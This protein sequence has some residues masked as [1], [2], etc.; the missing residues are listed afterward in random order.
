ML[1]GKQTL[2][3]ATHFKGLLL[4]QDFK[5][6]AQGPKVALRMVICGPRGDGNFS[7]INMFFVH[8]GLHEGT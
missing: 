4:G 3:S 1:Y 6:R 7:L 2:V 5:L 8:V